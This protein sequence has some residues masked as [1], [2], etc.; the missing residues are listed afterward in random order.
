MSMIGSR[1]DSRVSQIKFFL[2][3]DTPE[4]LV[5]RQLDLNLRLK[6]RADFTDIT[7]VNK[8][9]YAWFLV[10]IDRFPEVSAITGVEIGLSPNGDQE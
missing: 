1:G 7:F 2:S 8:K 4:E 10:D 3:A 9:W 6:A 5:R